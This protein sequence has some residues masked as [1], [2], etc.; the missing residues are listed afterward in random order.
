M[1]RISTGSVP[2]VTVLLATVSSETVAPVS[3]LIV[4]DVSDGCASFV[5]VYA[6]AKFTFFPANP[7]SALAGI[8]LISATLLPSLATDAA[9]SDCVATSFHALVAASYFCHVSAT[10]VT[11]LTDVPSGSVDTA[12]IPVTVGN[13]DASASLAVVVMISVLFVAMIFS[14]LTFQPPQCRDGCLLCLAMLC[15]A[16]KRCD[17]RLYIV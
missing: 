7:V 12:I 3:P 1:D 17:A 8:A 9:V 10:F 11:I 2:S 5:V 13:A 15:V 16:E 6:I 14:S 4:I